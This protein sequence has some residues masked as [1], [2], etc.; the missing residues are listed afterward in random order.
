MH[1]HFLTEGVRNKTVLFICV[2]SSNRSITSSA[3]VYRK[4][5]TDKQCTQALIIV[6]YDLCS[7]K[8]KL[9]LF[10][11]LESYYS[12]PNDLDFLCLRPVIHFT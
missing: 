1:T 3:V 5:L 12:R 2:F 6:N 10:L 9:A 7:T 8:R 4:N 11:F